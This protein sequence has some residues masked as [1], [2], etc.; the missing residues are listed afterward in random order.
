MSQ[1]SGLVADAAI[2][3]GI[4]VAAYLYITWK[5][6]SIPGIPKDIPPVWTPAI[7]IPEMINSFINMFGGNDDVNLV[8]RYGQASLA[9]QRC[10]SPWRLIDRRDT[11]KQ[12]ETKMKAYLATGQQFEII[13]KDWNMNIFMPIVSDITGFAQGF[14][15][16][17]AATVDDTVKALNAAFSAGYDRLDLGGKF[18]VNQRVP[19]Y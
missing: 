18:Y 8:L 16:S 19:K 11:L 9:L 10:V 17:P 14:G 1:L 5:S 15:V 13:A 12:A 6:D 4:G 3:A 2:I 7:G